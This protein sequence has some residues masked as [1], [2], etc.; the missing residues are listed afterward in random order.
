MR[1]C[2]LLD[3]T[4]ARVS[5]AFHE[6]LDSK[7]TGYS[8]EFHG[9]PMGQHWYKSMKVPWESRDKGAYEEFGW[10]QFDWVSCGLFPMYIY[11]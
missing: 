9:S 7:P 5:W 11:V 4:L 10:N 2:R 1:I 8:W 3:G 6:P